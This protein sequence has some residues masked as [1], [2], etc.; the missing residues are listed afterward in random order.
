MDAIKMASYVYD[1][2]MMGFMWQCPRCG[3]VFA[4]YTT[5]TIGETTCDDCGNTYSFEYPVH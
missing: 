5:T 1:D 2:N 3:A 4:T